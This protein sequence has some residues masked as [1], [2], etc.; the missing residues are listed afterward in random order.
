MPFISENIQIKPRNPL[1]CSILANT[2]FSTFP[3]VSGAG[4]GPEETLY[5]PILDSEL[6]ITGNIVSMPVKPNTPT[7]C[8][9]PATITRAMM[10]L[11]GLKPLFINAGLKFKPV[12]P[13]LDALGNCSG[14]SRIEPSLPDAEGLFQRG[15]WIGDFFSQI[16]D[17]LVL[18]ECVPG[19][20]T[21]ALCVARA[22]GYEM[23]VSSSFSK[24]PVKLKEEIAARTLDRLKLKRVTEPIQI[25]KEAGDPMMPVATGIASSYKGKLFLAGGTQMM[26]VAALIKRM[27]K[28]PP[29]VVT[30]SYV[31]DD[32][33]ADIIRT[34]RNIGIDMIYIDPGFENIGI[35]GLARYCIGEVKEGMGAGGALMLAS[36]LAKSEEEIRDAIRTTVGLYI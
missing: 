7:G 6:I 30:T 35:P 28:I 34:S 15:K 2:I 32:P 20:T 25:M 26:A 17:M 1:F 36:I 10:N 33:S 31:R 27:G 19:G 9:T 11:T 4:P 12:I 14:D 13:V 29:A 24:N 22:L 23:R 18:G 16:S 5:T 8:P 21:T 3:G